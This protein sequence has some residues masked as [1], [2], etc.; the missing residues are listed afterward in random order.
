[1]GQIGR[2]DVGMQ[3]ERRPC[4]TGPRH[5]L[6]HHGAEQEIAAAAAVFVRYLGAQ[7][8]CRAGLQPKIARHDAGLLP[9][10]VVRRD[11]GLDEA[12]DLVAE[13]LVLRAEQRAR[14]HDVHSPPVTLIA[15]PVM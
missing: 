9:S 11:L 5:L 12:A 4:R 14:D 2:H 10:M 3:V 6:D 7:Q 15:W 13:Q 1:M 8:P